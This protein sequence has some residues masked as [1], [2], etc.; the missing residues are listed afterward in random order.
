MTTQIHVSRFPSP[1]GLLSLA[2]V[3]NHLVHLD[4]EDHED[5][6][7]KLQT[8]RFRQPEW[9]EQPH[10]APKAITEW[11]EAYFA[12]VI[13]PL[14]WSQ[15]RLTGTEFQQQ[16][17]QGLTGIPA[18]EHRSYR[19]LAETLGNPKAV[20]A[21]ARANALNPVAILIPCHRVIG[22]DGSL[23]GYA[24]GLERKAWL[25]DHEARNLKGV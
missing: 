23:T 5:R 7:H 12:G 11:L 21:V 9:Q 4:F 1:V 24:G 16:V 25:L 22:A 18:G 2:T 19:A 14:P 10:S 20:R 8:R 3:D 13:Q 17:W 15:I 6:M